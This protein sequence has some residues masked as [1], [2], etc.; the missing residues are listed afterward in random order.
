M[1]MSSLELKEPHD[2]LFSPSWQNF[3]KSLLTMHPKVIIVI[4]DC[5]LGTFRIYFDGISGKPK[6]FVVSQ[7]IDSNI[8]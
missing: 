2:F 3:I 5:G 1:S 4:S 8:Y 6:L 7:E